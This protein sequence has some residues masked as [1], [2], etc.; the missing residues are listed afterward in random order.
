M[1]EKSL[2]QQT[3]ER[4]RARGMSNKEIRANWG[5]LYREAYDEE[6]RI[7]SGGIE[8]ILTE[9]R[10]TISLM[11]KNP[12]TERAELNSFSNIVAI[13][14]NAIGKN[15]YKDTFYELAEL[16]DSGAG[17]WIQRITAAIY[18]RELAQWAQGYSAYMSRLQDE[19]ASVF[20]VNIADIEVKNPFE[21]EQLEVD[22]DP[23]P[24]PMD[25]IIEM[26]KK[27]LGIED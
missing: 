19:I 23:E 16:Y 11:T 26:T 15:G 3:W 6:V 12:R 8:K 22:E 4:G 5:N 25:D 18:D 10:G 9:I 1:E 7:Y 24:Q 27:L 20:D 2:T 21:E 13:I 14:K 17:E